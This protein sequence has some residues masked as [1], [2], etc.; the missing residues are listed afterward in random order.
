MVTSDCIFDFMEKKGK[1]IA[2][3]ILHKYDE[4]DFD[5]DPLVIKEEIYE[6]SLHESSG[7]FLDATSDNFSEDIFD[8]IKGWIKS[9][10]VMSKRE[11]KKISPTETLARAIMLY[12][13]DALY[14]MS[15]II[16]C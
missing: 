11:L 7:F 12:S 5:V 3:I 13:L 1:R 8:E 16:L 9:R 2:T 6:R 14:D 4:S 10:F 15:E